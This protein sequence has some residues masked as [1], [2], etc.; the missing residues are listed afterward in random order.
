MLSAVST[1]P[2]GPIS[3]VSTVVAPPPH[4]STLAQVFALNL[5]DPGTLQLVDWKSRLSA[6][7]KL[8]QY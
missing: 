7:A 1:L 4:P 8:D 3:R 5:Q 2:R 6:P